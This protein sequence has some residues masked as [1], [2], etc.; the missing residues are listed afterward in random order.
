MKLNEIQDLI[1][2]VAKSGVS[3]VELETKD[4]KI[5]IK[6]GGKNRSDAPVVMQQPMMQTPAPQP[7]MQTITVPQMAE[8][9]APESKKEAPATNEANFV[10]I[11]SPMIGTRS[12]EHTSELQSPLNLV[13]RLLLEKK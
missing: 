4:V 8:P 11:K 2:F 1:K 6:T 12:E 10:T 9:K 13:C 5:T 3:E 7:V